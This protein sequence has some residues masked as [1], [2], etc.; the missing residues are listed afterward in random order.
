VR[1]VNLLSRQQDSAASPSHAPRAIQQ[2]LIVGAVALLVVFAFAGIAFT[3]DHGAVSRRQGE[4]TSL[5]QQLASIQNTAA[6][7]AAARTRS[8]RRYDAVVGVAAARVPW[9]RLLDDV[10]RV[11][12]SGAWLSQLAAEPTAPDPANP[13]APTPG[14]ASS[15]P[16]TIE[17][18]A[19]SQDVVAE[20]L[21][22]LTYVPTLTDISLQQT[23]KGDV[24]SGKA[25]QFT[26]G[27]G[28]RS[29]G[30]NG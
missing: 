17:G 24:G 13:T 28:V 20:L 8:E 1:P 14:T 27:A 6:A 12:P 7:A 16:V 2:T 23:Q 30:G 15:A 5:R 25:I 22:R 3:R 18:Y 9:D 19:R 26:I 21:H 10:S 29:F 11:I 4:L